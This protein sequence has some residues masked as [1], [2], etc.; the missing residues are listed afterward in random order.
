MEN[1]EHQQH[2]EFEI[3]EN[4]CKPHYQRLLLVGLMTFLGSF[5]ASYFLMHQAMIF[6]FG[7]AKRHMLKAEHQLMN[8]FDKDIPKLP[9]KKHKDF[10]NL[11]NKISAIQS[12]KYEDAYII[13]VDLKQFNNDENNIRFNVNGNVVTVSGN[14]VK[15]RKN[16]ENSYFFT[17]TFEIPEK[18][19]MS[20]ITKEKIKD[21]Y[22]ITLPIED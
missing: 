9:E 4:Q 1:N 22:I 6:H 10:Q 19:N 11:K 2:N 20:E 15:D 16:G 18:I 5:L 17:E 3:K 14:I 21:K 12:A 7:L 13:V 8:D